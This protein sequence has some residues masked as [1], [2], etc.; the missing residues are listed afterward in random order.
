AALRCGPFFCLRLI[1]CL[2]MAGPSLFWAVA[3]APLRFP[4]PVAR[5]FS[6]ASI[7][8]LVRAVLS[9]TSTTKEFCRLIAE[10]GCVLYL[11]SLA[12]RRAV[13]YGRS[14]EARV[15]MFPEK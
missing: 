15:E 5:A 2:A 13:Y 6:A 12:G 14:D 9:G 10:A 8:A 11:V 4:V 3:S 1:R 7:D